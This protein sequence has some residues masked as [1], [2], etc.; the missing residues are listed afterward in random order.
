MTKRE[1]MVNPDSCLSKAGDDEPIFVLRAKDPMAV[2]T[3]LYW[4][5]ISIGLHDTDKLEEAKR[6]CENAEKWYVEH[7]T[8]DNPFFSRLRR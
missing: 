8:P 1:E 3:V 4:A 6:W 5:S 7:S 2:Q